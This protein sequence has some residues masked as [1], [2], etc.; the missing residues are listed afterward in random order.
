M[1][2][3]LLA[4]VRVALRPVVAWL[5]DRTEAPIMRRHIH[6]GSEKYFE[7]EKHHRGATEL[8]D[9][10]ETDTAEADDDAEKHR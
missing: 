3:S 6:D 9:I 5:D 7:Y 1:L 2:D 8:D 10:L 4:L